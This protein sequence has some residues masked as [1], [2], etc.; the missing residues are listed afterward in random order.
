MIRL[1]DALSVTVFS[2]DDS[3]S[4]YGRSC[5]FLHANAFRNGINRFVFLPAGNKK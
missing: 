5:L 4:N 2:E 1:G 3:S